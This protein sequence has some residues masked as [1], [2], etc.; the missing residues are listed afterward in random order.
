MI[1]D[2]Y[3][4]LGVEPGASPAEI[5]AAL[6][7]K[8]PAWSMGT[9]N[10]KTRHANQLFLDEIPVLRAALLS[11]PV[12]RAAYDAELSAADIA[13][14]EEKL[15]EL[16]RLVRLRAAKGGLNAADRELLRGEA[17]RLGIDGDSLDRL[18][19]PIPFL[20]EQGGPGEVEP[21]DETPPDVLDASTR[22]QIRMALDHLD[23]RDL[24]D[25]LG[26]FRD[27]PLALIASRADEERQRW[28]KKAQVTAEKTAWLEVVSHAQTH[29]GS[30][31]HRARY[32]RTL[33]LE[34]E[35]RFEQTSAFAVRGLVRIDS[36]THVAL[37][38]EAGARGIPP[39]RAH[40]LIQ[41]ACR[42]A[43]VAV[44]PGG[45]S[46]RPAAPQN[47]AAGGPGYR[48]L[49]C[50]NCAGVTEL[51]P[52]ARG[53]G[54]VR[55]KHCGASLKWECPVCKRSNLVD[56]PKCACGFRMVLREALV[57]HF[58]AA[59]HAFRIHDLAGAR[60]HL[61]EVQKYAP[62]H[63]GARNGMSRIAERE[64][65][66]D[67]VRMAFELAE[68]GGRLATAAKALATW[69]K[70]V[71]AGSPE[72]ADA[73]GR[74]VE[75]LRKAE[76]L[77]G[78]ARRLE[79][80]DPPE[81]RRLYGRSLGLAADLP[82]ALDGL[83][84]C[85]PDAPTNL[86]ARVTAE[87]VRLAWL[88][89]EPDGLAAPTFVI[90]RK[91]GGLPEHP[92]DGTRIAEVS[93][94]EFEDPGVEPGS[95]VS[96]AVLSRRGKSESLAAVA[97]GPIVF[98]PDV[99]NLRSQV[100]DGEIVLN[101]DAPK[102]VAEVRVVRNRIAVPR[103]PRHGDRIAAA[104]DTA[105]D[106]D[107]V[108]GQVYHYAVFAIYRSPEG[109]RFPSSG[110]TLSVAASPPGAPAG[111]PRAIL[112]PSGRVRIEWAE[113]GR[114]IVRLRR[115]SAPLPQPPGASV[116]PAEVEAVAGDWIDSTGPGS[117]EDFDP[118]GSTSR[119]YTPLTALNGHLIVGRGVWL[120]RLTDPTDLR[121]VRLD[122]TAGSPD[123]ARI[124]LRWAWPRDAH[125]AR[126][127]A[128][129]GERPAGPEDPTAL[130][131][132][133]ARDVYDRAGSWI[134]NA[135]TPPEAEPS[136]G[137]RSTHWH[138]RVYAQDEADGALLH[139][140]GSEPSAETVVPGP[141]PEITVAY[142]WKRPWFPGRPWTLAVRTEPAGSETPP[143][144]VVAN[145]RAVP[146]SVEDGEVIARIPAGRDGASHA[147]APDPR[148][149]E[150]GVRAFLD[151]SR[152]PDATPPIRIRHPETGRARV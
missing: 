123:V 25:A 31:K 13:R 97:A 140:P 136:G 135:P 145:S 9:R 117:A 129:R 92:G 88:P 32:D 109:R 1:A 101:W 65:E 49:R 57:R 142:Q 67:E 133:V 41:R 148:L 132:S 105:V 35:D 10:P 6:K 27:A 106:R 84:R 113:P 3:E 102:G 139:S 43:G 86:D 131:F 48:V 149:T 130:R 80:V 30:P 119:Y 5:E 69:R 121:A 16:H 99:R 2:Y 45:A 150:E 40:R 58:A 85:P 8:Q 62:E 47:G 72:I 34:A 96:Y 51:S 28:M 18:M 74:I 118:L 55:C 111:P 89:P 128:R 95:T 152:D 147:I 50:R 103:N 38:D 60:R 44:D 12:N 15:D 116:S 20:V 137:L 56:A 21:E 91:P 78:R 24:Y 83:E 63:V 146:V 79:R 26:L 68:A 54:A 114:G 39:D 110:A 42:K 19:R 124:Q 73:Q 46:S 127:V 81:A 64:Q 122:P 90:L 53:V 141:H 66:L 11:G 23:R 126:V 52:T 138:V 143:M 22:R 36:G 59:L 14:R 77:A 33:V 144:V 87:G 17:T 120:A 107:V 98:L 108:E 75:R 4:R 37:I 7:K 112:D 94:A 61:E 76:I 134:L 82:A 100:R 104:S 29:L 125:S 71:A 93:A 151:P 115:T 70:L